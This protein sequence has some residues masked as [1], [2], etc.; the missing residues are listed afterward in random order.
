M[1]RYIMFLDGGASGKEPVCQCSRHRN[2]VSTPGSGRSPGGG[3]G[4]PS[5]YRCLEN[6]MDR[7]P[8]H[9]TVK[10]VA[11]SQTWLKQLNMGKTI[12]RVNAIP[13]KWPMTFFNEL[14]QNFSQFVWKHRRLQIAKSILRK[15]NRAGGI[16]L[17]GFRLHYKL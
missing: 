7:G 9:S 2:A 1:E 15:K 8:W 3:H 12:Y 13:T 16:N 14:E 17:P 11:E 5:Q 10:K 4:N 6:P